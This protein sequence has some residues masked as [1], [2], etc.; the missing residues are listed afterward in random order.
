MQVNSDSL[1]SRTC[2]PGV[3]EELCHLE[4]VRLGQAFAEGLDAAGVADLRLA[5]HDLEGAV[6]HVRAVLPHVDL[7]LAHLL[8]REGDAWEEERRTVGQ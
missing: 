2:V 1:F 5:H 7:V 4:G 6:S 8:G 3:H